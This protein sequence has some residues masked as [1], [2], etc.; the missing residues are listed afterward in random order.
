[1]YDKHHVDM[2]DNSFVHTFLSEQAQGAEKVEPGFIF[3]F[4]GHLVHTFYITTHG[5]LSFAPKIHNLMYKTQYIAP[6]RIKLDP[7]RSDDATINYLSQPDRLT[8]EWRNVR[9]AKPYEHPNGG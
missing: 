2:T 9:V 4:Y 6:L 8:I 7:A 3:P 1:M 5:F